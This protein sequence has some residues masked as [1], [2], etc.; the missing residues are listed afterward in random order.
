MVRPASG[1]AGGMNLH[2][3]IFVQYLPDLLHGLRLTL[4]MSALGMTV[5]VTLGLAV[6]VVRL[7]KIPVL[8]Q[9]AAFFV[10]FFRNTPLL[11]QLFFLFYVLPDLGL[12]IDAFP[13]GVFSLG[14]YYGAYTAEVYRGGFKSVPREQWE[15]GTS[16]RFSQWQVLRLVIIPQAVRPV[17]PVLGNYLI[18]MFKESALLSTITIYELFGTARLLSSLTFEYA[19]LFTATAFLYLCISY[20]SSIAMRS[21]ERRLRW[22]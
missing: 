1:G 14:T 6:A 11:V 18:S 15:T 22:A 17:V 12:V 2:W 20:P 4:I 5:A 21:L 13:I 10:F 8:A 7:L 19:T 16:L 9:I 3:D